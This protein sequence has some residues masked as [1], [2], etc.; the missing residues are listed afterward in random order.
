MNRASL[1]SA[2][3]ADEIQAALGVHAIRV[4][5]QAM[6]PLIASQKVGLPLVRAQP[7]ISVSQRWQ[8]L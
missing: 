8:M 2:V 7:K 3:T 1:A 4:I 5:P 6:D